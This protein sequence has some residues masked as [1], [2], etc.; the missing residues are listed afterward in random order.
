[1][2]ELLVA[3]AHTGVRDSLNRTPLHNAAEF[4]HFDVVA[5]LLL[6]ADAT[7]LIN[8][9]D[10]ANWTPLHHAAA[11]GHAGIVRSLLA[12]RAIRPQVRD[13]LGR[14]PLELAV[15][16]GHGAAALEFRDL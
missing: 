2:R 5:R 6:V 3:K 10:R 9:K 7:D 8:T 15:G 13:H 16:N 14:T 4:G 1:M 12:S 11:N